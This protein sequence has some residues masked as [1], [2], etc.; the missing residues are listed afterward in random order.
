MK[1]IEAQT[2]RNQ[3]TFT[4]EEVRRLL[5][6]AFH[7]GYCTNRDPAAIRLA[8]LHNPYEQR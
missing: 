1:T 8:R 4:L 3:F 5:A 6:G 2:K 7:E